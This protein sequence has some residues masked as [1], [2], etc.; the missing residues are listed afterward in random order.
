MKKISCGVAVKRG[1]RGQMIVEYALMFAVIVAVI[2][3][4]SIYVVRPSVGR[5]FNATGRIL[6][7]ATNDITHRF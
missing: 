6:D 4:A 5:F 3:Y 7:N 1:R 2:I